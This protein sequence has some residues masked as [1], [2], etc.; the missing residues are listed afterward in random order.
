MKTKALIYCRVSSTKQDREGS[1][2]SS[3][4]KRCRDYAQF[5]DY[6]VEVVFRDAFS[7]GGN[8][9]K[10]PAMRQL[11]EYVDSH[12]QEKYVVIFDDLKRFARDLKFHW[13]L[14]AEF[15]SRN[16]QPECLNF[17]FEE[18]PEGAFIET[19]IAA[20][21]ELERQQNRRQVIQKMKARLERGIYCFAKPFGYMYVPSTTYGGKI[22][23]KSKKES[24]ILKKAFE[25]FA[26]GIL[27]NIKDVTNFINSHRKQKRLYQDITKRILTNV[28]YIGHV[29][30]PQ[31]NIASIKGIHEPIISLKVFEQVQERIRS[32][33]PQRTRKDMTNDFP[34]RGYINCI[35]C[36]KP[37]TASWSTSRNKEKHAYY[38]CYTQDCI[39][40]GKSI[41]SQELHNQYASYI[42]AITPKPDIID[43]AYEYLYYATV[44]EENDK[45]HFKSKHLKQIT[46]LNEQ[47]SSLAQRVITQSNDSPLISIYEE[48]INKL[49]KSKLILEEEI[50]HFKPR[51]KKELEP[52]INTV[53]K[54]FKSPYNTWL[55]GN[56]YQKRAVQNIL[57]NTNLEFDRNKGFGTSQKSYILRLYGEIESKICSKNIWVDTNRIYLNTSKCD[58]QVASINKYDFPIEIDWDILIEELKKVTDIINKSR[59]FLDDS[60]EY[61]SVA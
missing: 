31:W 48:E 7:G 59:D 23:Q 22:L 9:M 24:D 1:G 27:F 35:H 36:H 51:D 4:E 21:G 15:Q 3:Q 11:L 19:I 47:I 17:K 10:R 6:E 20:Q 52:L 25:D 55:N 12:P 57:F 42:R 5:N 34:L 38:R 58:S 28:L 43:I 50:Q 49:N 16:L 41:P 8:F 32:K 18:T 14:R 56:F 61:K 60:S 54:V 39:M 46:D 40:Y 30:Y 53:S 37:F 33:I 44:N 2:L 29:E 45:N 13:E 26:C